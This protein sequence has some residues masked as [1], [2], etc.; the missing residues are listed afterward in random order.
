[1]GLRNTSQGTARAIGPASYNENAEGPGSGQL[2]NT[3]HEPAGKAR[4]PAHGPLRL[5]G[6]GFAASGRGD[7]SRA[8]M[9]R[10]PS[11]VV[12]VMLTC[13]TLRFCPR[14]CLNRNHIAAPEGPP[15]HLRVGGGP[16]V[17]CGMWRWPAPY[18][19]ISIYAV[20]MCSLYMCCVLAQPT[21]TQVHRM[22]GALHG[23]T[24]ILHYGFRPRGHRRLG[25]LHP[26]RPSRPKFMS[27]WC[28]NRPPA[29]VRVPYRTAQT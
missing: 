28:R 6:P 21:R 17:A 4:P 16:P 29:V 19:Y 14:G 26:P 22:A 9:H 27:G 12:H 20:C 23:H 15:G 8:A 18:S 10:V 25:N 24:L 11:C 3:R 7:R 2:G 13:T 1:M 5:Q